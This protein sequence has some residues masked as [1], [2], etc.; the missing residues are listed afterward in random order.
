MVCNNKT[1]RNKLTIL[2][3]IKY[4]QARDYCSGWGFLNITVLLLAQEMVILRTNLGK[5][6]AFTSEK[7][8]FGIL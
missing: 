6:I 5:G 7:L 2:V 4:T 3:H 1:S 8:K